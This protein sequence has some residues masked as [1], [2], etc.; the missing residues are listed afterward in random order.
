[1]KHPRRQP[2]DLW[3]IARVLFYLA[4]RPQDIVSYFRYGAFTRKTPLE[5]RMP[6]WS[7][8]AVRNLEKRLRPDHDVFEFGSGGSTIFVGSRVRSITCIEDEGEWTELVSSVAKKLQLEGVTVIHKPFDFW[9]TG[10]FGK[11]E[12]LLSLSGRSYDVIIVDGKEW[13]DPVRDICFWRAEDHIKKG[14]VII[15]DDSWRYPQVKSRNR[16]LRWK[17]FKGVGYCRAGVT[18]TGIF[19]Y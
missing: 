6:W 5:L 11:S 17:E 19:E 13:S 15:L 9:K 3:R 18:S 8:G 4:A 7:F 12:Y 16:A 10:S 14:G 2:R 1:M